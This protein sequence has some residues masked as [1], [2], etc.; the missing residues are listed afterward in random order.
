V[1]VN[2]CI[3]LWE[4]HVW[5]SKV[6]TKFYSNLAILGQWETTTWQPLIGQPIPVRRCHMLKYDWYGSPTQLDVQPANSAYYLTHVSLWGCH[7]NTVLNCTN[8]PHVTFPVVPRLTPFDFLTLFGQKF[9]DSYISHT[10]FVWGDFYVIGKLSP[11]IREH[12]RRWNFGIFFYPSRNLWEFWIL[13]DHSV[14]DFVLL[15]NW[16][17]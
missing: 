8:M 5:S 9:E 11:H 12:L 16:L 7:V 1:I 13:L 6:S 17:K 15:D 10:N 14:L 3:S 4:T 2:H